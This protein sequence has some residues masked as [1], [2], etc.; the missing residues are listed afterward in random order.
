[1]TF[2]F[3]Q[4]TIKVVLYSVISQLKMRDD[5]YL[6]KASYFIKQIHLFPDPKTTEIKQKKMKTKH[7]L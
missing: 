4:K 2:G 7:C 6:P 3:P 5:I 1:M